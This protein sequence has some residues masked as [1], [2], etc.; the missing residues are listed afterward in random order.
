MREDENEAD[1]DGGG[2][3]EESGIE[4]EESGSMAK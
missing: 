4:D 1:G 2:G 3:S